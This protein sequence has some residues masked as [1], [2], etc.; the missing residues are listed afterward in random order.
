MTTYTTTAL[1][2]GASEGRRSGCADCAKGS[3]DVSKAIFF[4][5][6]EEMKR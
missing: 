4:S 6:T 3:N 2:K 5:V 1:S